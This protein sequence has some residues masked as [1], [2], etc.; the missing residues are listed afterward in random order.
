MRVT[1]EVIVSRQ[2]K[3]IVKLVKLSDRKHREDMRLFRFDGIKLLCEAV[4]RQVPLDSLFVRAGAAERLDNRMRD[5]YGISLDDVDCR[6][7]RVSEELFDKISEE[8]SPEGVICV[9]NYIDKFHKM[10]KIEDGN[11]SWPSDASALLLESVRDPSNVGAILRSAAALGVT[12]V[13]LSEDCA[14]LYHSKT[15]RASMGTMFSMS[16]DRVSQLPCVVRRLQDDGHRVFA[17]TLDENAKP[18]DTVTFKA[19]DCVIIGNEG[20][21]L[22][23]ETVTACDQT[24]YIPMQ[25]QVESLNAAV[26]AALFLWEM[27]K[28]SNK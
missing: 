26:A 10:Y 19:G 17:S 25:A 27:G 18:L 5:L 28:V 7:F 3:H 21:G 13:I 2:N 23:D 9:A 8:K 4:R 15:V 20:H 11:F 12:H 6:M 1:D 14:D 16:I 24:L 22:Q